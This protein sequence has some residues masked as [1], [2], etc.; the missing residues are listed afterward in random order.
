MGRGVDEF[1]AVRSITG[2][3]VWGRCDT[4]AV[5]TAKTVIGPNVKRLTNA[6]ADN[7]DFHFRFESF[8]DTPLCLFVSTRPRRTIITPRI[9]RAR[10]IY[11]PSRYERRR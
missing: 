2:F 9:G 6:P 11:Y 10:V 7:L 4:P 1:G 8:L 3:G 5:T